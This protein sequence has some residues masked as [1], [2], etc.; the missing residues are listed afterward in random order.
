LFR[1]FFR[2]LL[3]ATRKWHLAPGSS[4]RYLCARSTSSHPF[5]TMAASRSWWEQSPPREPSPEGPSF[6]SK[7]LPDSDLSDADN[8][9]LLTRRVHI[10]GLGSIGTLVAHSLRCMPNPPPITLMIHRPGQYEAFKRGGRAIGLINKGHEI[11]DQQTGYDIDLYREAAE[12]GVERW[13]FI[14]DIP[15]QKHRTNPVEEAEVMPS[16]ELYI[17]TLIVA[18]KGPTTVAALRSLKHRVNAKTTICFMQN[19]L[20]QI[21]ELNQLVFTDPETRPTYMLGIVSH[22]AY[23]SQPCTVIHAGY[24]TI[25]L[26]ICR[27]RDRYPLPAPGPV[28]NLWELTEEE[29][30]KHHPTDKEL[31]SNLSSRYLLRTL[32]R[33]PVLACAVFP[34]LDLLQ[35]QL[36][37][38]SSNCILNPLTALLDVPNGALLNNDELLPVQR[39]LLAEISLVIRGLPE[40]E[41]I[42]N[43][44]H[45]F[46]AKRLERLFLGVTKRTAQNSSSMREDVRHGKQP[47]VDYINGYIVKRGEQQG[48][49]CALNFMLMQLIKAKNSFNNGTGLPYGT[50]RIH[51]D[52]N[53][54]RPD[55]VTIIDRSTPPRGSVG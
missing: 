18:V 27:D 13:D 51:G 42:P 11:N 30:K 1:P 45:R 48:I 44:R 12:D 41:G 17:Y 3:R 47:E 39:L 23:M 28:R 35:L 8:D 26:G 36:E 7:P 31:F 10:L 19:G 54:G 34:Y 32:T 14:P 37:K 29:R 6:E 25:A 43:V 21:E 52:V 55:S 5:G 50:K 53:P 20:G 40:L 46:S 16:G 38:L 9:Q 2:P 49:K 4:L 22:G 24:G 15:G 33:S